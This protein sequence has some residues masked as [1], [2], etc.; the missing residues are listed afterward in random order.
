ME[1]IM[2]SSFVFPGKGANM[3]VLEA[4]SILT[5]ERVE[6]RINRESKYSDGTKTIQV[7]ISGFKEK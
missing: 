2:D 5:Q 3:E 1:K 4:I 6:V 7:T